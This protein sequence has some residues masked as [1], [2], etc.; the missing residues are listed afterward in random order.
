[1]E[2]NN[3]QKAETSLHQPLDED[4]KNEPQ[5][6]P[7][8]Y[9]GFMGY[10]LSKLRKTPSIRKPCQTIRYWCNRKTSEK[11]VLRLP[12]DLGPEPRTEGGK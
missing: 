12:K 3:P 7:I 11:S 10:I 2:T 5:C 8:L 6:S 4:R 9:P 1:M